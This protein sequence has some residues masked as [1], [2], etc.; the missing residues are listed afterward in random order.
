MPK[1]ER[2]VREIINHMEA[3][4]DAGSLAAATAFY[5]PTIKAALE[6]YATKDMPFK[7]NCP[8]GD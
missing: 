5:W 3:P 6:L 8:S 4:H 1:Q 2:K 7:R